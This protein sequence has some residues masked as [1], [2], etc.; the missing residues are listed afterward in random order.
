[1]QLDPER[2]ACVCFGSK[3]ATF[4]ALR[5]LVAPGESVVVGAPVYPGHLS[6]VALVGADA[7][8]WVYPTAPGAIAETLEPLLQRSAARVL[9]LNLPAN[10]TGV[11]V[12]SEWW[13]QLAVV[14]ARHGVTVVNDF[15]YGEMC[16]SGEPAESALQTRS[17]GV[18]CVEVYSLSK[19]YNVPGW[20]VGALVGDAEVVRGVSRFKAHSDYG[21]FLPLQHAAAVALTAQEDLVRPTVMTYQRRVRL[22][23]SG[24]RALGWQ[25]EEPRAGACVWA[26]YP[27][28]LQVPPRGEQPGA[29]HATGERSVWVAERLL[30]EAGVLVAPGI[31]FGPAYDGYVRFAAVVPEERIRE[32]LSA[33]GTVPAAA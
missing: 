21:L 19:A 13:Q 26:K 32:V 10:P 12:C 28:A 30:R 11:V 5:F 16:F 4:Q 1:V 25:V 17:Q 20:R 33:L 14:C 6:A 31:V 15:V 3:D 29:G 23:A 8:P 9:L 2:E 7:V 22:L 24:L 27:E 18:R